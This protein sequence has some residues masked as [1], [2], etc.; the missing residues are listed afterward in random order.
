MTCEGGPTERRVKSA[1]RF[2]HR[3]V[4]HTI[5]VNDINRI[6]PLN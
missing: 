3:A 1:H 2:E 5:F 4:V 6:N